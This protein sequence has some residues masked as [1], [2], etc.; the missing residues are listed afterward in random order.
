MP[1]HPCPLPYSDARRNTTRSTGTRSSDT[2]LTDELSAETHPAETR[3]A[4]PRQP[5]PPRTQR[6][7]LQRCSTILATALLGTTALTACTPAEAEPPTTT[8]QPSTT[9][10]R[11]PTTTTPTP[12]KTTPTVTLTNRPEDPDAQAALMAYAKFEHAMQN[13][14]TTG[15]N[16]ESAEAALELVEDGSDAENWVLEIRK[17][18]AEM[19]A[20]NISGTMKITYHEIMDRWDQ[21]I[22]L[23]LC[24]DTTPMTPDSGPP[25][26]EYLKST[27]AMTKTNSGWE[28]TYYRTYEADQCR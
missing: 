16:D 12:E 24:L 15:A 25:L 8:T 10:P 7:H 20:R 23:S 9:T 21:T 22:Q 6:P 1:T 19:G 18:H 28:L 27:P 3:H 4:T 5:K 11:Q 13:M 14:A 2:R 17:Q 26:P